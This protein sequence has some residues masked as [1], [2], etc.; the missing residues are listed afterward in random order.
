MFA[1]DSMKLRTVQGLSHRSWVESSPITEMTTP[2]ACKD[3]TGPSRG[4]ELQTR[5]P[6]EQM[7]VRRRL[8]QVGKCRW[9]ATN[10]LSGLLAKPGP[11]A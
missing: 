6:A 1:V 10:V 7:S 9:V 3:D 11:W 8:M 4:S 5:G 2:C